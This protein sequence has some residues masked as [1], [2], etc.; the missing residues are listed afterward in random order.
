MATAIANNDTK[1]DADQIYQEMVAIEQQ[2]SDARLIRAA[3]KKTKCSSLV[4]V[5]APDHQ[6]Q[7][8]EY[9][10]K[11]DVERACLRQ[12]LKTITQA[13]DTPCYD[14]QLSTYLGKVGETTQ[15]KDILKG[16]SQMPSTIDQHFCKL[17]PQLIKSSLVSDCKPWTQDELAYR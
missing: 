4:S 7:R 11:R 14:Q 1:K 17:L 5:I 6:G 8:R 16:Q 15:V 2:R 13:Q 3:R 9:F 10:N 12:N